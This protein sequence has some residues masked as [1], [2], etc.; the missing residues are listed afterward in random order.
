LTRKLILYQCEGSKLAAKRHE[1]KGQDSRQHAGHYQQVLHERWD[2]LS[3]QEQAVWVGKAEKHNVQTEDLWD[4]PQIYLY[5]NF[6][7][8]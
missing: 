2:V 7:F 5:M 3:D 6:I 8:Q 4:D 1:D